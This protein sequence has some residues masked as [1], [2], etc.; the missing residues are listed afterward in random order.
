MC[1]CYNN[2]E[3]LNVIVKDTGTLILYLYSI[4]SDTKELVVY[5]FICVINVE[6]YKVF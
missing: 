3:A 2:T 4:G 5:D 6:E 1:K